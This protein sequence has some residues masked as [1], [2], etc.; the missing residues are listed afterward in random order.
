MSREC[1]IVILL[2]AGLWLAAAPAGRAQPAPAQG[3]RHTSDEAAPS[4]RVLAA[5]GIDA[6][7]GGK[8]EQARSLLLSAHERVPAD[9]TLAYL[10]LAETHLGMCESAQQR[11]GLLDLQRI[12]PTLVEHLK[13][14]FQAGAV[15]ESPE[16][17][18]LFV[19]STRRCDLTLKVISEPPDAEVWGFVLGET[20]GQIYY[21]RTPLEVDDMCP[22]QR[23]FTLKKFGY[24]PMGKMVSLGAAEVEEIHLRMEA[25]PR[26][27]FIDRFRK[28]A[29]VGAALTVP[30]GETEDGGQ[31]LFGES[32][33]VDANLSLA[34]QNFWF[35]GSL[36]YLPLQMEDGDA[37]RVL[38]GKA[39]M[40][41]V[42]PLTRMLPFP[43]SNSTI[44]SANFG[45]GASVMGWD[46]WG[47]GALAQ[48]G[49]SVFWLDVS[50]FYYRGTSLGNGSAVRTMYGL[51]VGLDFYL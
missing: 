31:F 49:I 42:W 15:C 32:V 26:A 12:Q 36:G 4:A 13:S 10:I 45:L 14:R 17:A 39:V 46:L 5:R 30:G 40:E 35:T 34:I 18:G 8:Y 1:P 33:A 6:V 23:Q 24:R 20:T 27:A 50:G 47:A 21:G 44:F 2:V 29:S 37:H 25:Y 51:T 43:T 28:Y 9:R 11:V 41:Y 22:G 19:E 7:T 3:V 38:E 16:G 48:G